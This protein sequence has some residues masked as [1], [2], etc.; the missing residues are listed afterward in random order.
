MLI[1]MKHQKGNLQYKIHVFRI[2]KGHISLDCDMCIL[3]YIIVY[4]ALNSILWL[5]RSLNYSLVYSV[6]FVL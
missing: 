4:A 2:P 3:Y 5:S 6:Y 1:M